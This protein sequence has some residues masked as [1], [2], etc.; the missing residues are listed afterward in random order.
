MSVAIRKTHQSCRLSELNVQDVANS[1]GAF[2]ATVNW[3]DEKQFAAL[4]RD[5]E[6]DQYAECCQ[7][8]KDICTN[9]LISVCEKQKTTA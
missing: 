7:H 6:H 5:A 9:D 2:F 8:G 1:A 3:G 4:A